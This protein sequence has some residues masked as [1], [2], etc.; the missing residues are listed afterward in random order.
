[1]R[2]VACSGPLGAHRFSATIAR[3]ELRHRDDQLKLVPPA[4]WPW[5][6]GVFPDSIRKPS[7]KF[8]NSLPSLFGLLSNLWLKTDAGPR[9]G[10]NQKR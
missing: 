2:L 9:D 4:R 5:R 3:K 10:E 8:T 7:T 1:M 6:L